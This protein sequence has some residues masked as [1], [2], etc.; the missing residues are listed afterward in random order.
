RQLGAGI[1]AVSKDLYQARIF[2]QRPLNQ[3]GCTV[4]IL[5]IPWNYLEREEVSL[6]VDKG[7]SLNALNFLARIVA[8]RINGDPP[9][10]VAFATCVS[11]IAAP[12]I[13]SRGCAPYRT[14]IA[15]NSSIG[16]TQRVAGRRSAT[17]GA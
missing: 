5:D 15:S 17:S 2:L 9:F 3:I 16:Q 1:A 7:V 8:D 13:P 14:R 12:Q 6:G 10:S 4:P 11:M